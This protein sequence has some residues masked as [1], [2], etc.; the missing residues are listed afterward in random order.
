MLLFLGVLVFSILTFSYPCKFMLQPSFGNCRVLLQATWI[1]QCPLLLLDTRM[2]YGSLSAGCEEHLDP[3][4][5]GSF[6]NEGEA[7][8]VVQ[9]VFSLIYSGMNFQQLQY[10]ASES[11]TIFISFAHLAIYEPATSME[12]R[13]H[14]MKHNFCLQ[15][16]SFGSFLFGSFSLPSMIDKSFIPSVS[17]FFLNIIIRCSSCHQ[18]GWVQSYDLNY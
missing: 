3:A 16:P 8:I 18:Q 4:G 10:G 12:L 1:T 17:L 9:H 2:Q 13:S 6:Y 11:A 14:D 5:T 15:V 7:D